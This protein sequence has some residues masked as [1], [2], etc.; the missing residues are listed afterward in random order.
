M[1]RNTI[2]LIAITC[3]ISCGSSTETTSGDFEKIT[4]MPEVCTE[5]EARNTV[6]FVKNNNDFEWKNID[7]R[8][9][10][11]GKTY[12]LGLAGMH[13]TDSRIDTFDLP[14]QA[15]T[16]SMPFKDA[17][18]FSGRGEGIRKDSAH[19]APLIRL[20]NFSNIESV[21]IKLDIPGQ[22]SWGGP[23]TKCE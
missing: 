7:M 16:P 23:V 11:G 15:T 18:K 20:A 5:G 9:T 3:L 13:V 21:T 12:L 8:L 22:P 2:F 4:L 14:P 6:L 19:G 17:T 10:K 1:L